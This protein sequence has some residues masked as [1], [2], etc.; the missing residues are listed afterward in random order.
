M[1]KTMILQILDYDVS[2]ILGDL[3]SSVGGFT[4]S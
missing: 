2:D 4:G 1:E 3:Q